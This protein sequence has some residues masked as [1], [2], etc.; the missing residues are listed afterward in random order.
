MLPRTLLIGRVGQGSE[1]DHR[2]AGRPGLGAQLAQHL[3]AVHPGHHHIE[4]DQT[5]LRL[6]PGQ[7]QRPHP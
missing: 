2:N 5:W 6:Q 1:K 3:E 7:A 4:Q